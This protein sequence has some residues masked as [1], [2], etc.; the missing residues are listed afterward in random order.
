MSE[1]P[2]AVSLLYA[3]QISVTLSLI[4]QRT[5]T[6]WNKLV[7]SY[8][9]WFHTL[10]AGIIMW[11][12]PW[13][14]WGSLSGQDKEEEEVEVKKG[15]GG[16]RSYRGVKYYQ[17]N[18]SEKKSPIAGETVGMDKGKLKPPRGAKRASGNKQQGDG[19]DLDD[20]WQVVDE[21]ELQVITR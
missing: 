3:L 21:E 1:L 14:P 9:G 6:L 17:R 7:F 4:F 11:A 10:Y 19:V 12:L 13:S 16:Q 15:E 18:T 5:V 20:W 2:L 8:I